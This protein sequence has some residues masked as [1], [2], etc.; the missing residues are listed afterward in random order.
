MELYE[1]KLALVVRSEGSLEDALSASDAANKNLQLNISS[2]KVEVGFFQFKKI[3]IQLSRHFQ[4]E[5]VRSLLRAWEERLKNAHK[6]KES[7][8][9]RVNDIQNSARKLRETLLKEK[10][11][12][13]RELSQ[14]KCELN[15][16][17]HETLNKEK[18]VAKAQKQLSEALGEI[19]SLHKTIKEEQEKTSSKNEE[20]LLEPYRY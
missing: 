11:Q 5:K 1:Y 8:E 14:S 12:L 3:S 6:E 18:E 16:A 20:E 19:K 10:V 9:S 17:R 13:E 2:L 7:V 4:N 15:A